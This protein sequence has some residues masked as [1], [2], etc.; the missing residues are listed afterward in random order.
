MDGR[1]ATRCKWVLAYS[2]NVAA[3]SH[4]ER[5]VNEWMKQNRYGTP[6]AAT[7]HRRGAAIAPTA[8]PELMRLAV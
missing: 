1:S 7:S 5:L 8:S 2:D 3:V 4:A 6:K